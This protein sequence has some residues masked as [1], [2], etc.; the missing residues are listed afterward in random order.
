MIDLSKYRDL[1]SLYTELRLHTNYRTLIVIRDGLVMENI[2][3]ASRGVSARVYNKGNFAFS[4]SPF[5]D[6]ENIKRVIK[7]ATEESIFFNKK[8]LKNEGNL[9]GLPVRGVYDFSKEKSSMT[10][11]QVMDR[12]KYLYDYAKNKYKDISSFMIAYGYIGMEKNLVTS[13]G[14]EVYSFIPRSNLY[15]SLSINK[16]G[17]ITDLFDVFG[18]FGGADAVLENME[19]M[20]NNLDRLYENVKIKSEGIYPEGGEFEVILGNR[21]TGVLAHEA[22]G[23]TVEADF[24]MGG[25]IA[26]DYLNKEIASSLIT[27][28]D[29][30]RRGFDGK[31]PVGVFVDD[32]GTEANDVILIDKGK[33]VSYMHNKYSAKY[34]DVKP[35]GNARAFGFSDEPLIRMRNTAIMPGESSL[36]E[37]IES[38]DNGYYFIKSS[39]GQA[40]STS[41][42][43]FGI[44][45]GYEIKNGKL[46]KPIKDTT[47]SG[48]AFDMLKTVTM[49]GNDFRWETGNCGKKQEMPVGMG[50]PSIK[51]KITVGGK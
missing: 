27:M 5:T 14:S 1:F 34:F 30:G 19:K 40:D 46:G 12:L 35:T 44:T 7:E 51:C 42:F 45:F 10:H 24:V 4:S 26:K 21:I 22:I 38:I 29:C 37:M 28:V 33:L 48:V 3:S 9:P 47:I 15:V 39:N 18:G 36:E 17:E 31:S 13:E 16:D 32:E 23:H 41:E 20:K 8:S 43:M 49:V 25:S 50:G 2:S 6:D 11:S